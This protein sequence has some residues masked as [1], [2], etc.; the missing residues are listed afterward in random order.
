MLHFICCN[1]KAMT[2]LYVQQHKTGDITCQQN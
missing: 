1:A 2:L